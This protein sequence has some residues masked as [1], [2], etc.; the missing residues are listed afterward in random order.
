MLYL[1]YKSPNRLAIYYLLDHPTNSI[2][3]VIKKKAPEAGF[4]NV[5]SLFHFHIQH[6]VDKHSKVVYNRYRYREIY[7]VA[8]TGSFTNTSGITYRLARSQM[9]GDRPN[10]TFSASDGTEAIVGLSGG[11]EA[12]KKAL[13]FYIGNNYSD[14]QSALDSN[15][16]ESDG[17]RSYFEVDPNLV[18]APLAGNPTPRDVNQSPTPTPIGGGTAGAG[19][20]GGAGGFQY[21]LDAINGAL[22]GI[23]STSPQNAAL[24][25]QAQSLGNLSYNIMTQL[26]GQIQGLLGQSQTSSTNAL[27]NLTSQMNALGT[28]KQSLLDSTI[29][30]MNALT[31]PT[32]RKKIDTEATKVAPQTSLFGL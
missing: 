18:N 31:A 17:I 30:R 14:F 7:F 4:K 2:R 28:G 15:F 27:N 11:F 6:S 24:N 16:L 1:Y 8:Y 26:Q 19:D 9:S 5:G 22:G 23:Q 13:E 10:V 25:A 20:T 29:A 32:K 3:A 12:T 21:I